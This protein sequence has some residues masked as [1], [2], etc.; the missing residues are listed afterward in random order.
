MYAIRSYYA[1]GEEQKRGM[2]L[3][4]LGWYQVLGDYADF[5]IQGDWYS[6]GSWAVRNNLAYK[7]R[8]HFSGDFAF[9]YATNK[10]N[11]D[12]SFQVTK[13]YALKWS[14][15]QDPKANPTQNFSA[16]VNFRSSGFD[17]KHSYNTEDYTVIPAY[18]I[19]YTKLYERPVLR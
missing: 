18:S 12:P 11:D 3:R 10:D 14:H 16:S 8:Y 1:Y 4:D 13:D 19:H 15:R 6:K 9:D 7:W 5:T 17:S 2:Y